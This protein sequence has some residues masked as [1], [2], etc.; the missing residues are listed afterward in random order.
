PQFPVGTQVALLRELLAIDDRG[1]VKPTRFIES[2]Q[3]RVYRAVP[4]GDPA[5]PEGFDDL[6]GKQD[7]YEF[8][9]ARKDLFAGTAGG[10]HAVG[11]QHGELIPL[12][13]PQ[14]DAPF[15]ENPPVRPARSGTLA[16]CSGCHSRPGIHSVE[17]YRRSF[18]H[19]PQAPHLREYDRGQQE[20]AAMLRKW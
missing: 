2:V 4:K 10:L 15:E 17:A 12:P 5:H 3:L 16:S 1:K 7:F 18:I 6:A 13:T 14:P 19:L 8:R 11:P 9:I 20:R